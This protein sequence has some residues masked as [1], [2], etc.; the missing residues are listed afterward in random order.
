MFRLIALSL[1]ILTAHA[2]QSPNADLLEN[3]LKT[4]DLAER[5]SNNI[6]EDAFLDAAGL[7]NKYGYPFEEHPVVTE[8][9]YILGLHRIPHGR[10]EHN[11]PGRRPAVLVMHGLFSSSADFIIMGPGSALAYILAEAGYDVWLGNARGT[12]Y[13]RK[14][15]FLDPNDKR[16]VYWDFSWDEIGNKDIPAMIDYILSET[17]NPGLHYIG[18]SQGTTSFFVMGS[19]RP[20]YNSKIITMQALAPVAYLAHNQ[21]KIFGFLAERGSIFETLLGML[22]L[23]E[24]LPNNLFMTML[25]IVFCNDKSPFQPLCSGMMFA[26]AGYNPDQHNT[27]MLPAKI[28]HV[29]A[30]ASIRQLVHYGQSITDKDFRRYDHGALR[31]LV[32]YGTL[33]P[34][35]YRLSQITA[36]VYLHYS[37]NDPLAEVEDVQRLHRE[38][39]GP[40]KMLQV[41]DPTFSHVD[42]M[43]GID[44]KTLVFDRLIDIMRLYDNDLW[45]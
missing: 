5:Y 36:P 15:A 19:L 22:G 16:G 14:H 17:G 13:S 26:I 4:S 45:K 29:P 21:Q 20:E 28:G 8:D 3:L 27:T 1:C 35:K 32:A 40:A 39:G 6:I 10:D 12:Y 24:L 9:G 30:G 31:N 25:G 18:L 43:W 37:I 7:A 44:A 34:P 23:K 42:F 38:L 33:V 11:V 41:P 2:R